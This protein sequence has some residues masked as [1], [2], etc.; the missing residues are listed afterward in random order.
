MTSLKK[1]LML[2]CA[3]VTIFHFLIVTAEFSEK[4]PSPSLLAALSGPIAVKVLSGAK[5]TETWTLSKKAARRWGYIVRVPDWCGPLT[6]MP[7]LAPGPLQPGAQTSMP[8]LHCP[9]Q[10]LPLWLSVPNFMSE[11]EC[12]L[13]WGTGPGKV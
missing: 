3:E 11:A 5:I 10:I 12:R 8:L 13:S 7:P 4:T 2:Q 1:L 9:P 6:T